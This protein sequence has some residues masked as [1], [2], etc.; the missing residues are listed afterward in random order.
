MLPRWV[1]YAT[2]HISPDG[3]T[4]RRSKTLR[5]SFL[6]K[7][8]LKEKYSLLWLLCIIIAQVLIVF[9]HSIDRL[10]NWMGVFYSPSLFFFLAIL[11]LFIMILH[12]TLVVSKLTKQNQILAQHVSLLE[13]RLREAELRAQGPKP[14]LPAQGPLS[15]T[16]QG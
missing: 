15:G 14:N 9:Y 12:L 5:I 11:F 10:A 3:P 16:D 7:E 1:F 2:M 13:L 4:G 6:R 8:S